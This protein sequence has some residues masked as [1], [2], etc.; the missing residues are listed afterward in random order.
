VEL[1]PTHA[2]D[3]VEDKAFLRYPDLCNYCTLCEDVCPES[4][5]ALPFLIVLASSQS[6]EDSNG[7]NPFVFS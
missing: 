5:I 3:Q 1:C 6:E 4:A 2:L 7:E